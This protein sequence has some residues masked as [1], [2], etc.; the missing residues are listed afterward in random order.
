MAC[1]ANMSGVAGDGQHPE[2]DAQDTGTAG[3]QGTLFCY[4]GP[5]DTSCNG[6]TL[7]YCMQA[8]LDISQGFVGD[9]LTQPGS[10]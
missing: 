6:M 9:R 2:V 3:F 5:R 4:H 8:R 10:L 1:I 7:L